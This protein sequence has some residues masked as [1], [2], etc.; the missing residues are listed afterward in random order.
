V[1]LL[2]RLLLVALAVWVVAEALP[3]ITVGGTAV[4]VLV[5]AGVFALVNL[6][7]K[8]IVRLLTLPIIWLTLGLFLLVVNAAMLLLTAALTDR[9]TVDG[10]GTAVLGGLLISV[11]T[12]LGERALGLGARDRR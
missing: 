11:V 9:L 6:L 3:G 10:F 7:V 1:T 2:L 4:D 12:W 5:V 8:P